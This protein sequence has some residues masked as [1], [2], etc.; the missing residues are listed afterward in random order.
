MASNSDSPK[1]KT[2]MTSF[3][4]LTVSLFLVT[5]FT[6]DNAFSQTKDIVPQENKFVKLYSKL[7]SFIQAD[8][9]SIAFYSD[10]FETEFTRFIQNN[11]ATLNYPFK[12]LVDSNF[13]DV[14]TSGDS[15]FRIYSWDTWT[16]GTM[17]V[18]KTIYQW[19]SNG[20]VFTKV[21]KYEEGDPGT[22][23]SK[24]FTINI[25]G[26]PYY[27]AVTNGV[28][29]TKDAM[30]SISTY[31]ITGNKLVDTVKLFKTKTKKLNSIDVEFDFFSVVD[32]PERPLELITYDDKQKI[33]YI[34]VVGDKG[35]VT[36]RNILYQ[37][38]GSYFEFIGIE[39]G[40]RK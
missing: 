13:C 32:R 16:G 30:Q 7:T 33:I 3:R 38:K 11:P 34:P 35:Q 19:K 22:F 40:M 5:V 39:T 24:I 28:M 17:H 37:L 9:D 20:K 25:N 15:D 10:K 18:F 26:K 31:S 4:R 21:P 12:R 6:C 36:K 8:Y 1:F 27:L 23:C 2:T 29:S 14:R